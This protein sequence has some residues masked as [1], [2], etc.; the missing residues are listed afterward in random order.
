M[1][2][3]RGLLTRF[4]AGDATEE[5][6]P[7]LERQVFRNLEHHGV[8]IDGAVEFAA[9]VRS[10]GIRIGTSTGYTAEMCGL[11]LQTRRGRATCLT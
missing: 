5:L 9:W 10:E 1:E 2:H 8:L 6:Y 4:G 3:L 11:S 7:E